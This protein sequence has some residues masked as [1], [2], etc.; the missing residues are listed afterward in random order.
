MV[1]SIIQDNFEIDGGKAGQHAFLA[2]FNN[3]FLDGRDIR[4]G[5]S[6]ANDR[7]NEFKPFSAGQ[8]FNLNPAVAELTVSA[9]LF[10]MLALNPGFAFNGFPVGDLG[11]IQLG[12]NAKFSLQFVKDGFNM[13]LPQPG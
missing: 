9:R 8:G 7:I 10:L 1:R 4:F 3:A 5:N 12:L 11:P 6:A 2:G 13:D